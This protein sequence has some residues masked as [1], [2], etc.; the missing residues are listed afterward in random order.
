M[1]SAKKKTTPDVSP[2]FGLLSK[3]EA[4]QKIAAGVSHVHSSVLGERDPLARMTS[5]ALNQGTIP[6]FPWE[7]SQP[8]ES[9]EVSTSAERYEIAAKLINHPMI[10]GRRKTR[11]S[12]EVIIEELL[13]NALYHAYHLQDGKEK[14]PRKLPVNLSASEK[15]KIRYS[16]SK[17]GIYLSVSD[18]GGSLNFSDISSAFAR[19]YGVD[20]PEIQG[21]EGGAG[22]GIFM[23]FE[24][25]THYKAVCS[26]GKWCEIS[27][28]ISDKRAEDVDHFSFNYFSVKE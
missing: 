22:L 6:T 15:L 27:I 24:A 14:Y 5:E 20:S 1:K 2:H 7:K 19:T 13:T 18:H 4:A 16:I 12:L 11:E 8:T 25:A 28:W 10:S 23:V 3:K 21:K 9:V 26:P 17:E